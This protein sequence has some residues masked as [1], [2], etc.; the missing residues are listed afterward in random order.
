MGHVH[1]APDPVSRKLPLE[2]VAGHDRRWAMA[3]EAYRLRA[4]GM[5]VIEESLDSLDVGNDRAFPRDGKRVV[6]CTSVTREGIPQISV[7]GYIVPEARDKVVFIGVTAQTA[8]RDRLMTPFGSD[9]DRRRDPC[10][11]V[12]DHL[13][14][15]F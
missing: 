3:L 11:G 9:D 15:S 8:A 4:R 13:A 2:V 5:P 14:R 7:I 6:R 1:A 10:P 12:R